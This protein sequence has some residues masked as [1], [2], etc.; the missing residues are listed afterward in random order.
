MITF[1]PHGHWQLEI[2]HRVLLQS[3]S[4]SWNEEAML[5][6]MQEFKKIAQP[7]I[8]HDWAIL[9]VFEHWELGV[10]EIEPHIIEHCRWFIEHGCV[11]DCH[12]YSASNSKR[13]QL[14][15]LIPRKEQN[16]ERQVFIE[17]EDAKN[18]LASHGF[19][20]SSNSDFIRALSVEH[21]HNTDD[22]N[23]YE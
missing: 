22:I 2:N 6:Y 18:W 3:F 9:S 20:L 23:D 8:N 14:E 21:Q 13:Q 10:P 17:F 1:K 5:L 15:K 19:T 4:G 11:K 16:Y 12:V 7:L